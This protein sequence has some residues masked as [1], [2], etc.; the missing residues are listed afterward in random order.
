MEPGCAFGSPMLTVLDRRE[1]R[2]VVLTLSGR[3]TFEDTGLLKAAIQEVLARYHSKILVINLE[4]VSFI[5]SS[6]VGLL[7]AYRNRMD[8]SMGKLYLC[9]L[10]SNVR[11][12]LDKLGLLTYLA[13]FATERDV[14]QVVRMMALPVVDA[15]CN[16]FPTGPSLR[17]SL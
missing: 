2:A 12:T 3:I 16:T 5:D 10:S 13:V 8:T 11:D 14:L 1:G 7:V 9:G 15:P 17:P 4:A 6:G